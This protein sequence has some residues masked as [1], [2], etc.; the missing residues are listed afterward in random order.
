MSKKAVSKKII[1]IRVDDDT[2]KLIEELV[3]LGVYNSKSEAL[4]DLIR[5]GAKRARKVKVIA[6][7]VNSL[8][9]LEKEE[10]DIPIKLEGALKELLAERERF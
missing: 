7:A 3:R 9:E 10:G 8:L 6:E 4:R 1:P 5:I 2:M